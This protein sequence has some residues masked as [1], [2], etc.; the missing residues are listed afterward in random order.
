MR[1]Q[2]AEGRT[3]EDD[4]ARYRILVEA[5]TDYAIYMLDPTGIVTSWNAGAQRFKGYAPREI[6]G[7]HFSRFYTDKD[8][9]QNLPARAL[10]TAI[11]EGK[12]ESEGW[13]VRK[14]GTRFWAHVVI[15]PIRDS[16]GELTG[17]AK[18][19]R[20]LTERRL[21]EEALRRSQEQFRLLVQGV[22]D[23]AIYMLDPEGSVT[24][25]NAGAER[26]KGYTADE[27]IGKHFS[28]FYMPEDREQAR[29]QRA[30]EIAAREGR[31]ES[32]GWRV[33]KDGTRFW[34]HVI[35]DP[36]R[37]D[38]GT[39]LGFA[40]ITR[41][42][43]EKKAAQEALERAREAL[44][45]SQKMDAVGQLTGGVAH[46]FN[47]LLMAVLGSLELLRKRL[48]D[49]PQQLR[50]LDNAIHGAKRGAT[51][52][53]RML[54]FARRQ[55]LDIRPLDL[56]LLVRNMTDL[57]R[58]TLGTDTEIQVQFPLSLKQVVAD[59]NQLELALLN[60][61]VN[62]RDAMKNR[63][64]ITIRAQE[65]HVED[66]DISG[67]TLGDYVCLSISDN[68]EG[69]SSETLAR[70]T[71]PFFTTK[72]VGKGTG[73]GLSMVHG[74]TEQMGGR[75]FLTSKLGEGTTAEICLPAFAG[76]GENTKMPSPE[77]QAA[78]A[79]RPLRVLA[80]DDDRLV[81]FNTAAMLE[82]MGHAVVEACSG[83]EA[84]ELLQNQVF[85]LVI[86]DQAMP[87]MTG[88]QLMEAIRAFWPSL[89]VILAT[90]YAELPG[91][92]EVRTP[93]LSKPFTEKDLA[94]ALTVVAH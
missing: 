8:R 78:T 71:E 16:A 35:L 28:Q 75:L 77:A 73:L 51:L 36:I 15:D 4:G 48:P 88:V 34:S 93:Q 26:I 24:S 56:P 58:S 25:W 91:G 23:Y 3:P 70:A 14:D 2:K 61:C 63:G 9:A 50:L 74:M 52:T 54:A 33:R 83:E 37:D 43:T 57:L 82:D 18:I 39:L 89:P 86:T 20:N 27:I 49:D 1:R 31:F 44:F 76:A 80:V 21:A 85:D 92:I 53:Q 10:E 46:D 47:N 81:L 11:R 66:N 62:A 64:R 13:R 40:K 79:M 84:L 60:L 19:T 32:E 72:G 5:V 41:D 87:K 90:G 59:E 30:L 94:Q 65:R 29:P 55:Q 69:M 67:L 6:V 38:D 7:Q 17:F 68:G 22:T 12:F 45:Q 42:V